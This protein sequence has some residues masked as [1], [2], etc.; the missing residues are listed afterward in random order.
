[1][2]IIIII[3]GSLR[4]SV[5][6]GMRPCNL[7]QPHMFSFVIKMFDNFIRDPSTRTYDPC[8]RP[9]KWH[10]LNLIL[11]HLRGLQLHLVPIVFDYKHVGFMNVSFNSCHCILYL[12]S[13]V[14]VWLFN[15]LLSRVKSFSKTIFIFGLMPA[16]KFAYVM[17]IYPYVLLDIRYFS[18]N[19]VEPYGSVS[20]RRTLTPVQ[21]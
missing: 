9:C 14:C 2:I 5:E 8:S 20:H 13:I 4:P 17:D 6:L 16:L 7:R 18:I 12:F 19:F 1:M 21:Q 3:L 11:I 10:T 15:F